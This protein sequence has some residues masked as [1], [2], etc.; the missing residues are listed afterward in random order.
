MGLLENFDK[1]DFV[2]Q[3]EKD[4]LSIPT[5]YNYLDNFKDFRGVK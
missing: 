2:V 3:K 5:V 1:I 4:F